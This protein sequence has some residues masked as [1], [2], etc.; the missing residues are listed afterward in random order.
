MD[1]VAYT[2]SH[3]K[4]LVVVKANNTTMMFSPHQA[5][6]LA[7]VLLKHARAVSGADYAP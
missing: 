7:A 2:V 3:E 6:I 1:N 5:A 4:G